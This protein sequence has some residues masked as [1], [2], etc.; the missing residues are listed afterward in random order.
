MAVRETTFNPYAGRPPSGPSSS[1]DGKSAGVRPADSKGRPVWPDSRREA[2]SCVPRPARYP[3]AAAD[4][5]ALPVQGRK[6]EALPARGPGAKRK[7][8]AQATPPEDPKQARAVWGGP[9]L[10][11]A[12]DCA[13]VFA[14]ALETGQAASIASAGRKVAT[15]LGG[16]AIDSDSQDRLFDA[17][18]L[19]CPGRALPDLVSLM[20]GTV[21]ACLPAPVPAARAAAWLGQFHAA[22]A[23]G[24]ALLGRDEWAAQAQAGEPLAC[25]AAA[26]GQP[27]AWTLAHVMRLA[28]DPADDV[29]QVDLARALASAFE[30]LAA[31]GEDPHAALVAAL[32]TWAQEGFWWGHLLDALTPTQTPQARAWALERL[33]AGGEGARDAAQLLVMLERQPDEDAETPTLCSRLLDRLV[34]ATPEGLTQNPD[35]PHVLAGVLH[36]VPRTFPLGAWRDVLEEFVSWGDGHVTDAQWLAFGLFDQS[37]RYQ[38]EGE[39]AGWAE[40]EWLTVAAR[41]Q[42]LATECADDPLCDSLMGSEDFTER[43]KVRLARLVLTLWSHDA[44]R[45]ARWLGTAAT[46]R[47]SFETRIDLMAAVIELQGDGVG[48]PDFAFARRQV[49][50]RILEAGNEGEGREPGERLARQVEAAQGLVALYRAWQARRGLEPLSRITPPDAA[51]VSDKLEDLKDYQEFLADEVRELEREHLPAL[52]LRPVLESL[53]RPMLE[54]VGRLVAPAAKS[55]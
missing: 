26:C 5:E 24:E 36:L 18:L 19:S 23:R 9:S 40:G 31:R 7:A 33:R 21:S 6:A 55:S 41:F 48:R 46:L 51:W 42:A 1:G 29:L 16:D 12:Q 10:A 28:H 35:L 53:L 52:A 47:L 50:A 44:P 8:E 11:T 2:Q 45:P 22:L 17:L 14:R 49:V 25:M 13:R 32:R 4:E 38:G 37:L 43:E 34:A 3:V 20:Q 15:Q 39:G 54:Q 30:A 27:V